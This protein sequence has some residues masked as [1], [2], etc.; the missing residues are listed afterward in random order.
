MSLD[1]GASLLQDGRCRFR[2]WAPRAS[3]VE[4]HVLSPRDR[5]VELEPVER[6]YHQAVVDDVPAGADYLFRLDGDRERPDPASRHQPYGV[7]GASRVVDPRRYGWQDHRWTGVPTDR[8]VFYEMHPGVFTSEGTLDAAIRHLDALAELGVTVVQLMPLGQFPGT[9]NWGYDGVYPFAV[10][11]CYGGPDALRRFVDACHG[12]Q[13]GVAVDVVYNHLG[14]EGNYLREFGPYFSP[15][16]RTPWGDAM[17]FDGADSDEVRDFFIQNACYWIS[18]YHV[19]ALRLDAIHGIFDLSAVPFLAELR[20]AV[21]GLGRPVRVI[22]ESDLNDPRVVRPAGEGGLGLDAQWSDDFHHALHALLTGESAGYYRDFG[23]AEQLRKAMV[24]GFVYS[25]Q[26]SPYRRRRHGDSSRALSARR[27]VVASQTHDQVG[28]RAHGER[29]SSLV[30]FEAQKLA[31]GTLLLSPYL[32]LLFM[33]QEYGELAP[34]LYFV[35]HGDEALIEAVRRGRREE[36]SAFGWGIEV[37]DPQDPDTFRRSKLDH[38]LRERE[39]H[40]SLWNLYRELL[41]LRR[42]H[43]ALRHVVKRGMKADLVPA[44]R[45]LVMERSR[46]D[47]AILA[48]FNFERQPVPFAVPSGSRTWRLLLDSSDLRWSGPGA[49]LAAGTPVPAG[50]ATTVA[51]E[52]FL[53][54]S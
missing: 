38:S 39:P 22:A 10:A 2:V 43:P 32:P 12:R 47:S 5:L 33:G 34:F 7:H 14:P 42:E 29:L 31:A 9:R 40:R 52:S 15:R 28:N 1:V 3:R 24:E 25:G 53:V 45:T 19:D 27:F 50:S 17:N 44:R 21:H 54:F 8:L 4:V 16:Y 30:S 37:P 11:E 36:F 6:G 26:Y 23:G 51:P 13:L 49:T 20:K 46:G 48:V 35:D 41:H 18:E